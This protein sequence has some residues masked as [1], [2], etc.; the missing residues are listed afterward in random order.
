MQFPADVEKELEAKDGRWRAKAKTE[1]L[2]EAPLLPTAG[3]EASVA[4]LAQP[5]VPAYVE[6]TGHDLVRRF[7]ALEQ[8]VR[9]AL[10]TP[11][12]P[13]A[14]PLG[15]DVNAWLASLAQHDAR[16]E[17]GSYHLRF[18]I[19]TR[20]DLEIA[21]KHRGHPTIADGLDEALAIGV[22]GMMRLPSRRGRGKRQGRSKRS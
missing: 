7:D 22:R 8:L 12:K 21:M 18:S 13:S 9:R 19:K 20:E 15:D 6:G 17:R 2:H 4:S 1:P 14:V 5:V 10:G 3:E 16:G 11:S